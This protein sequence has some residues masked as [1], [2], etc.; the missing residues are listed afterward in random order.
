MNIFESGKFVQK[1]K[2]GCELQAAPVGKARAPLGELTDE[3]KK[4]IRA[5]MEPILNW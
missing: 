4:A 5:A 1:I 2:Y 3:E